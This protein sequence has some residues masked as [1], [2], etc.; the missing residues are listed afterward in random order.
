M[1]SRTAA[2][3][4]SPGGRRRKGD[5]PVVAWGVAGNAAEVETLEHGTPGSYP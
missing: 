4:S 5:S 3:G 2:T 1:I